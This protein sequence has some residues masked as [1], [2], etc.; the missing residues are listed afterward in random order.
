MSATDDAGARRDDALELASLLTALERSWRPVGS[1][2]EPDRSH[3]RT[4]RRVASL[5]VGALC[6][7]SALVAAEV[8]APAAGAQDATVVPIAHP[9]VLPKCWYYDD[10][11]APRVGG[12]VH[13]GVDIGATLG[14][15][16]FAVTTGTIT[17]RYLD[18][19][20]LRAGNALRLMRSLGL[21]VPL[22]EQTTVYVPS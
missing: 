13:E 3:A 19:P 12:R 20:G 5:V 8:R 21:S 14:A 6:A 15:P 9:P 22:I 10:F 4:R 1:R 16:V 18:A 7:G 11:G 17:A 2:V